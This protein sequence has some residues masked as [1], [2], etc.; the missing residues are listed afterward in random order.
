MIALGYS[1]YSGIAVRGWVVGSGKRQGQEDERG[2]K[3]HGDLR[4][5]YVRRHL[6]LK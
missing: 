5:Q 1:S 6:T 3:S 2:R 4:K